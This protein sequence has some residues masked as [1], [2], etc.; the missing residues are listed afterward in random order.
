MA[1]TPR[2]FE[3]TFKTNVQALML[4]TQAAMPWM[5]SKSA[6]GHSP[7]R[8]IIALS[9]HGSHRALPAYGLIGAS[10]AA[11]ESLARHLALELGNQGVNVN[12]VLAGLVASDSTKNLPESQK[13]FDAI[14]QRR[15]VSGR[16]LLAEM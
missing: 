12:V 9:S 13:F 1:A 3:A 7:R 10:K 6:S 5:Q 16:E 15:L 14:A 4:L 11:L 2:N 8:K